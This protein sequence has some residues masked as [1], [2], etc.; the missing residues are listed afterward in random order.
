MA[1]NNA[2]NTSLSGQSGTGAFVGTNSPVLTAPTLGA[3]SATSINF[4]VSTLDTYNTDAGGAVTLSLSFATPGD[5]SISSAVS[6]FVY[7]RFGNIVTLRVA[8]VGTPTYTTAS[9]NLRIT[10][11]PSIVQSTINGGGR[12]NS[13]SAFPYPSGT[14]MVAPAYIAGTD[15]IEVNAFGNN[16]AN[17]KL[18]TTQVLT[19]VSFSVT[20]SIDILVI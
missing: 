4:G 14:T 10:G 19:G 13:T 9:G 18:T 20:F 2:V 6:S 7:T 5:L 12:F 15:Y 1:T 17:A 16:V 8:L 3:A 11:L